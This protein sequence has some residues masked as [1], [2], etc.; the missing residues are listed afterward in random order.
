LPETYDGRIKHDVI[1]LNNVDDWLHSDS[2]AEA[3]ISVLSQARK[4]AQKE[5]T[6]RPFIG[7]SI[8]VEKENEWAYFLPEKIHQ[9][10]EDSIQWA[11][12]GYALRDGRKAGHYASDAYLRFIVHELKPFIDSMYLT[13]PQREHTLMAGRRE[14][15]LV[16]AYALCEYPQYFGSALC[17]SPYLAPELFADS[18]GLNSFYLEY[19]R[20]RLPAP[21]SHRLFFAL[22]DSSDEAFA[23]YQY[24]FDSTLNA[25][26]Y[27]PRNWKTVG[28]DG[29]IHLLKSGLLFLF[30]QE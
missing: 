24:Q 4:V 21:E 23:E 11:L 28:G 19:W 2:S 14:G 6:L 9:V 7:V 12:N 20:A 13:F 17:I 30:R 5:A 15:A 25:H 18:L 29:E 22:K 1:Y 27:G 8:Q 26:E 3:Q 16:S 10:L